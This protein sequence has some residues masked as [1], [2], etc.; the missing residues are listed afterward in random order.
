MVLILKLKYNLEDYSQKATLKLWNHILLVLGIILSI[1][2]AIGAF[3]LTIN[4]L[5][6]I[7]E[8]SDHVLEDGLLFILFAGL[9]IG[10]SSGIA[11]LFNIPRY[12]VQQKI[13]KKEVQ[14]YSEWE[15]TKEEWGMFYDMIQKTEKAANTAM[16]WI[17]LSIFLGIPL[18][19][20]MIDVFVGVMMF[21]LILFFYIG[22][23]IFDFNER[24]FKRLKK[25]S[26]IT[27]VFSDHG[28][29]VGKYYLIALKLPNKRVTHIRE[30][31]YNGM[32][33]LCIGT[34]N[35]DPGDS[36]SLPRVYNYDVHLPVPDRYKEESLMLIRRIKTYP[37]FSA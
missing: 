10:A 18:L 21:S 25:K 24:A 4:Y 17:K 34:S 12:R 27:V 35:Y 33:C 36:E 6:N 26:K 3:G 14:I 11:Y 30:E 28:I 5:F 16:V 29:L 9:T 31:E 23:K 7:L 1:M 20:C 2:L 22:F 37:A 19:C 32:F 13:R 8:G 15:Y